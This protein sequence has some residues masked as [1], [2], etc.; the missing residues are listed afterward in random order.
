M[1]KETLLVELNKLFI[2]DIAETIVDKVI[3]KPKTNEEL[4]IAVDK[5]C[6]YKKGALKDYGP[7]NT[8]DT[9][10]IT[11]MEDL[12]SDKKYFNDDISN[13]DVSNVTNMWSMFEKARSFNQ[14]ISNWNVSNVEDMCDMFNCAVVF[15]QNIGNW[16][17]SNLEY[18][19]RM[20][21]C[22]IS[23]NQN[24][25]NWNVSNIDYDTDMFNGSGMK[26]LPVWYVDC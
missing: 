14:D 2:D 26:T 20:F 22:A 21:E 25:D 7:I 15:N 5:W 17:V 9:S 23:F 3:F 24:L 11:N 16:N 18:A 19:G 4:Q 6:E 8:W 10:L 12:F 1:D 13:W